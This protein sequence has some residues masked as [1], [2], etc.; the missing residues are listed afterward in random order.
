[1][2]EIPLYSSCLVTTD[3]LQ[4]VPYQMDFRLEWRQ[5]AVSFEPLI[6]RLSSLLEPL[7]DSVT[8]Q[9]GP[10]P[11]LTDTEMLAEIHPSDFFMH[12]RANYSF[13]LLLKKQAGYVDYL[14][15]IKS[16]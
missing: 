3:L 4:K 2:P 9:T 8:R 10:P 7:L 16:A 11:N 15:K 1:M 13:L 6:S 5:L 12:G 14:V